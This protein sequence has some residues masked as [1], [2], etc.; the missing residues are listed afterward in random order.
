MV[1]GASAFASPEEASKHLNGWAH[2]LPAGS[3]FPEGV[4]VHADGRDVEGLR[5]PGHRTIHPTREMTLD[6]FRRKFES[7]DWQKDVKIKKQS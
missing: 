2:R 4:S 1:R 3:E 5:A 7:L 6:E